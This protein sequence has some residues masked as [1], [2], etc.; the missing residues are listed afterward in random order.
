MNISKLLMVTLMVVSAVIIAQLS[1]NPAGKDGARDRDSILRKNSLEALVSESRSY[2]DQFVFT[3]S[4]RNPDSIFDCYITYDFRENGNTLES[5]DKEFYG[6]VSTEKPIV[7]EFS[8]KKDSIYELETTIEDK[9][10]INLYKNKTEISPATV[11][12]DSDRVLE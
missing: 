9:G 10:G 3:Y 5:I 6:N 11:E 2:E 4:P 8:R 12:N 7:L 1:D